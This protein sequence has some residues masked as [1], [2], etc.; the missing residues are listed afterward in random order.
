M[1][2][3]LFPRITAYSFVM[4]DLLILTSQIPTACQPCWNSSV[5]VPVPPER[6]S[7]NHLSLL[8]K[9]RENMLYHESSSLY[10]VILI[11]ARVLQRGNGSGSIFFLD[12]CYSE[13]SAC[14]ILSSLARLPFLA[15]GSVFLTASRLPVCRERRSPQ[16]KTE[17]VCCKE[18]ASLV[19]YCSVSVR[20]LV[21]VILNS[22]LYWPDPL[23]VLSLLL[24]HVVA[25]GNNSGC[26]L[27]A[28]TSA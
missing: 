14:S 28:T 26:M 10:H 27:F 25:R 3:P 16:N 5:A 7:I 17:S 2:G 21:S 19:I 18:D 20:F 23:I 8:G 6:E 22:V 12:S 13:T 15:T 4:A 24:V 11:F 1:D 9:S